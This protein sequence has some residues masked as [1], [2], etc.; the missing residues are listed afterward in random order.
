MDMEGEEYWKSRLAVLMA[1]DVYSSWVIVPL[2][3]C[4]KPLTTPI[5]RLSHAIFPPSQRLQKSLPG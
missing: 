1:Y 4:N 2:Q 5:T 3:T